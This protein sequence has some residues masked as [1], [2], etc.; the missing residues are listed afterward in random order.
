MWLIERHQYSPRNPQVT[1]FLKGHDIQRPAFRHKLVKCDERGPA[2]NLKIRV[3]VQPQRYAET[4]Y[5]NAE[6]MDTESS[7]IS[8][9]ALPRRTNVGDQLRRKAA[10]KLRKQFV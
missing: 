8:H 6:G 2:G 1:C 3:R 5:C 4:E 10:H 9:A 7:G